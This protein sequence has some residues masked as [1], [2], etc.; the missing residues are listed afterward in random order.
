MTEGGPGAFAAIQEVVAVLLNDPKTDWQQV[1]VASLQ[2]HLIDINNVTLRSMIDT[3]HVEGGASFS[4]RSA[5][6]DVRS[7]NR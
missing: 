7:S 1:D 5:D 3:R 4:V 6:P 2:Q